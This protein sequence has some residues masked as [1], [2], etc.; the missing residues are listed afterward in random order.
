M[1][2]LDGRGLCAHDSGLCAGG[3]DRRVN[4]DTDVDGAPAEDRSDATTPVGAPPTVSAVARGVSW[5]LLTVAVGQGSWYLSLFVLALLVP[6][7]DFGVTAVA[8]VVVSFT[9]LILEA[10][11]SGSLIIARELEPRA[12]RRALIRTSL[13]GIVATLAFVALAGPIADEF[14]GGLDVG[15]LRVIAATVGLAAISIVPN[16][17][18]SKHLRFK[19]ISKI[20]ITSAT[21]ASVVAV[22]AAALGAGVWAL[23]VRLV[24]NQL[25]LTALTVAAA[26]DLMPRPVPG[27]APAPKL[28]GATAFLLIAG[29]GVVAWSFDNLT[30]GAFT[31]PTQ[32]GLYSLGFSL[33]YAPLTLVSW[34]VGQ[35]LLPAIAAAQD[36]E[37]ARRQTLKA[38]RMMALILLPL[39]PVAIALAPG[40]IPA[41]FGRKW[42]GMVVPF[43]ILVIVGIGQGIVN[44][45]G[46][47]LAGAGVTSANMRARID[48][49][50]ATA[51]IVAIVVG[52]N[53]AGIRGAAAAHLVT[54]SGVAL[55]YG[56]RG[57]RG[58]G[59][60]MTM[61]SRALRGVA[62]CVAIQATVTAA[63]AVGLHLAGAGSLVAG[64]AGAVAGAVALIGALRIGARPLL[65]EGR[66]VMLATLRR[67][68]A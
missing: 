65:D 1:A 49:V 46:E 34:S 25:L 27:A 28:A 12:V 63:V 36:E 35:V 52:V 22:V 55:A 20:T 11:T 5:K 31:N 33:A 21:I 53:V 43:Q 47:A 19:S 2:A 59:L 4:L 64:V 14:T 66:G 8:S 9:L 48:V 42:D 29:A 18:L 40:A 26:R 13:G 54:F 30:V 67:R 24:V 3:Y 6:P 45:L 58:I 44:T 60:S 10:G 15:V 37:A 7:R 57:G 61:L 51:T 41:V 32:L 16:A 50:W 62:G 68:T 56:W 38:V 39:L 17:L 23:A